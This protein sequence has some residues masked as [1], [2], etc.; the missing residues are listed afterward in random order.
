MQQANPKAFQALTSSLTA[1]SS[2]AAAAAGKGKL[3]AKATP[4]PLV[5][6]PAATTT[7]DTKSRGKAVL[8]VPSVKYKESYTW[9]DICEQG[10]RVESGELKISWFKMKNKD[11]GPLY[12]VPYSTMHEYCKDDRVWHEERGEA[13][14]K[15]NTPHW[16]AEVE[17]GR[18]TSKQ[19]GGVKGGGTLLGAGE[20]ALMLDAAKKFKEGMPYLSDELESMVRNLAIELKLTDQHGKPYHSGSNIDSLMSGFYKRAEEQGL[21]FQ[22]KAGRGLSRQRMLSSGPGPLVKY[23]DEVAE[24]ALKEVRRSCSHSLLLLQ[25][26]QLNLMARTLSSFTHFSLTRLA[27]P[28]LVC[29][30]VP[31]RERPAH[32][33]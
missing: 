20:K 27:L 16:R 24:P 30:A 11:D 10:A 17:R 19:P 22:I 7:L 25:L 2:P 18:A 5:P 32:S 1:N 14:G 15:L 3:K 28:S 31:G 23:R 21:N 12:K 33:R 26:L 9:D 29:C 6:V 8:V 13:G 4:S